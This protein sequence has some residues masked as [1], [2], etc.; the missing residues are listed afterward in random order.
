MLP[1]L[2]DQQRR[3]AAA[4]DSRLDA[5]AAVSPPPVFLSI[6]KAIA[7]SV[8]MQTAVCISF[9]LHMLIAL[10]VGFAGVDPR[11][12]TPPHNVMDVVLF[13]L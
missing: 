4:I 2:I 7:V 1:T 5:I 12:F 11:S 13:T 8:A 3:V 6:Q 9:G 10:G